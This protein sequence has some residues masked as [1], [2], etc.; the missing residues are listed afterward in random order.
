MFELLVAAQILIA[1]GEKASV[2]LLPEAGP[3]QGAAHHARY[4]PLEGPVV[5]GCWRLVGEN[6][7]IAFLDAD[8][9]R[10]PFEAFQPAP[11]S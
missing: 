8:A 1:Q 6:I 3:C 5:D 11:K 7:Q 4:V 9:L 10:V 2:E